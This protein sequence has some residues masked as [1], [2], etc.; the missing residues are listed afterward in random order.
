MVRKRFLITNSYFYQNLLLYLNFA[1]L[2]D[3]FQLIMLNL[4]NL[5]HLQTNKK[6]LSNSKLLLKL[7]E[8][9]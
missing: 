3:N 4:K 8:S 6:I 2:L 1:K 5:V 9:K 7:Q